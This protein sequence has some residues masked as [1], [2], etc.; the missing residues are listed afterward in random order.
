[1]VDSSV[2]LEALKGNP[3]AREVLNDLGNSPKFINSMVFSEML[4]I[5]LKNITGKS[6]RTL[7]GNREEILKHRKESSKLHTF[8]R[9]NFSEL[10]LTEEVSDLAFEMMMKHALLPNDA[11]ILA[12]A[13][14]YRI[15][16]VTLD[17]DFVDAVKFEGIPLVGGETHD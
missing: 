16:L 3:R 5:F 8:L 9:E 15:T 11:I 6:Y 2:I 14:F 17:S 10:P 13:K 1:M 7:R 4:F 12:T